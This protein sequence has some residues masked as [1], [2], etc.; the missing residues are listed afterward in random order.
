MRRRLLSV[1]H[2]GS[3]HGTYLDWTTNTS[4]QIFSSSSPRIYLAICTAEYGIL[5]VS[6]MN[7]KNEKASD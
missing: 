2:S 4:F 7:H 3:R 5:V 6:K 1:I